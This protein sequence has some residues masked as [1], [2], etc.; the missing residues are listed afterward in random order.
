VLA[1]L[2]LK[3]RDLDATHFTPGST[4]QLSYLNRYLAGGPNL[5]RVVPDTSPSVPAPRALSSGR[6]TYRGWGFGHGDSSLG[7]LTS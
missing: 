2:A 4:R 3:P 6:G 7:I 1:S 5:R